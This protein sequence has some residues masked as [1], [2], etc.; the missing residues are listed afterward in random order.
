MNMNGVTGIIEADGLSSPRFVAGG[1]KVVIDYA[2][3]LTELA[4]QPAEARIVAG[5]RARDPD[6]L[7]RAYERFSRPVFGFLLRFL[8]ERPAAE[9]VQQQVF[10]E[11]WQK[12]D[13]FDP[14]RG[15]LLAWIMVIARSRAM[16][17]SRRRIPE[18]R[19]PAGAVSA[20]ESNGS[21]RDEIEEAVD[22]WHFTQLLGS[23]PDEEAQ[24]LR[25]RFQGGLSQ[26]EIA[27]RTGVPLGTVKSRMVTALGR[28]REMMEMDS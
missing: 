10:L 3:P 11:V 9:D 2:L 25:Y 24:L 14:E 1:R 4:E 23:L 7:R 28:L 18:P 21:G 15:S 6:A 20:I 13:R 26:S 16:D 22:A 27:V 8:G 17:H 19:D 5:L 12:A